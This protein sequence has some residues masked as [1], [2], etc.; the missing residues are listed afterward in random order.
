MRY[1]AGR[2]RSQLA[3]LERELAELEEMVTEAIGPVG[4][5]FQL[6][7][8]EA[9]AIGN[10]L[11]AQIDGRLEEFLAS[12]EGDVAVLE[13]VLGRASLLEDGDP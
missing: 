10:Y 9:H 2:G 6:S 5:A 7:A 1:A 11:K 8:E 13:R 12:N 3:A 4:G